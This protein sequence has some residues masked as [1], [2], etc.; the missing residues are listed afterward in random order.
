MSPGG[1]EDFRRLHQ[2]GKDY[3]PGLSSTEQKARLARMSYAKFLADVVG[4]IEFHGRPRGVAHTM[5]T[6]TRTRPV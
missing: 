4:I 2:E 3:F 1:K 6:G 5:S